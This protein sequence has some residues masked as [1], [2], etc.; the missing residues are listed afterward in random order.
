MLRG[1]IEGVFSNITDGFWGY[2]DRITARIKVYTDDSKSYW[3]DDMLV[4]G[5]MKQK[6]EIEDIMGQYV[7]YRFCQRISVYLTEIDMIILFCISIISVVFIHSAYITHEYAWLALWVVSYV[8]YVGTESLGSFLKFEVWAANMFLKQ[9]KA[10][11][12]NRGPEDAVN[13]KKEN[14]KQ[15]I[16]VYLLLVL[17]VSLLVLFWLFDNVTYPLMPEMDMLLQKNIVVTWAVFL[18]VGTGAV[19]MIPLFLDKLLNS[20]IKMEFHRIRENYH[21]VFIYI[22]LSLLISTVIAIGKYII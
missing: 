9:Y 21:P 7:F 16:I 22:F 15:V 20:R 11:A 6:K 8:G 10:L 1:I 4:L 5:L 13:S 19:I 14:K 2:H 17:P 12:D 18:G 3:Q